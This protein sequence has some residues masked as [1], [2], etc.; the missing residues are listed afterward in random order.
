MFVDFF[1]AFDSIHRG[2]KEQIPQ[3]Y[4]LQRKKK[5]KNKKKKKKE[6]IKKKTFTVIM[7]L[8]RNTKV[9]VRSPNGNTE[10]FNIVSGVFPEDTLTAYL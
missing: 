4:G 7:M 10:F 9:K 2:K 3:V 1:K 8:Y 5:K 6:K